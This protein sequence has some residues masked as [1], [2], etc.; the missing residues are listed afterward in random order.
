MNEET[1][2]GIKQ[3]IKVQRKDGKI[4]LKFVDRLAVTEEELKETLQ[5]VR[6]QLPPYAYPQKKH[7]RLRA[8]TK[9]D[10]VPDYLATPTV[11][12]YEHSLSLY[13]GDGGYMVKP[14]NGLPIE[15][16]HGRVY[17][18]GHEANGLPIAEIKR[19]IEGEVVEIDTT[20]LLPFYT[21]ALHQQEKAVKEKG[22]LKDHFTV[23]VNDLAPFFGETSKGLN[24]PAIDR[25]IKRIQSF[26]D[27]LGVV[28]SGY[29]L[30]SA[31][32]VMNFEKYDAKTNTITY[33]TPYLKYLC[34]TLLDLQPRRTAKGKIKTSK[35]GNKLLKPINSY[36]L[37]PAF[38]KGRNIPAKNN[39]T[40]IVQL[41][42][43]AGDNIPHVSVKTLIDRNPALKTRLET[44]KSTAIYNQHLKRAF[45]KTWELLKNQ[46]TLEQTYKDI[47]LPNPKDPANIPTKSLI[48]TM[49][50]TFPHKGK[51]RAHK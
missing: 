27:F 8:D 15:I 1:I 35:N 24:K 16:K 33:T 44:A 49:V 19:E 32:T 2:T 50:F 47:E 30:A 41:I 34:K 10:P 45:T 29:S 20:T 17:I 28:P 4:I 9:S 6:L 39:V 5:A 22:E 40:L 36:L 3:I 14:K 18:R 7:Y 25:L 46:T 31:Y 12:G 43:K 13:D 21:I 23:H 37:K 38:T 11:K 26:N 42:E 51:R 48:E